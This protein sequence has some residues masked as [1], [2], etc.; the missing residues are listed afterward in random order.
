MRAGEPRVALRHVGAGERAGIELRLRRVG[1]FLQ[2]LHIV[3]AQAQNRAVAHDVHIGGRGAQ[4]HRLLRRQ[5]LGA[6]GAHQRLGAADLGD[7]A[8]TAQ[9]R[10]GHG[11]SALERMRR[12]VREVAEARHHLREEVVLLIGIGAAGRDRRAP[13]AIGD[14]DAF[15]GGA[16]GSFLRQKLRVGL[17]G[18]GQRLVQREAGLGGRRRR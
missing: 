6:R 14:G 18:D 17:I 3:L 1:L 12:D 13:A 11:Q 7:G 10:L 9:D 15:I 2:D 5:E 8:A 16:Q 4:Q